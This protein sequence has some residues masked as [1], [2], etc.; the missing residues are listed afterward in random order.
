MKKLFVASLI[1]ASSVASA[2]TFW[3]NGVLM[4]TICRNGIYFASYPIHMA[5]PVGTACPIRDA[6]GTVIGTGV[7]T[8]E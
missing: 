7:V 8:A 5:Q 3:H 6:Y 4:G 1:F 2:A